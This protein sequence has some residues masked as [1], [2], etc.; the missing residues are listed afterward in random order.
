MKPQSKMMAEVGFDKDLA[1][2]AA[3]KLTLG[4][5]A[6]FGDNFDPRHSVAAVQKFL[7]DKSIGI[8]CRC[9]GWRKPGTKFCTQIVGDT[10]DA[11]ACNQFRHLFVVEAK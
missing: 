1:L 10:G 5:N 2:M 6:R 4:C 11:G 9:C 8:N 3:A 7:D